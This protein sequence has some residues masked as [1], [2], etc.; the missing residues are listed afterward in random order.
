MDGTILPGVIVWQR[1][2]PNYLILEII[3]TEDFVKDCLGIVADMPVKMD[4]DTAFFR[5][6]FTKKV[7]C[8]IE[9]L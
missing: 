1:T 2:F 6:Q 7:D 4:V 5:K 8:L 3:F 9:P